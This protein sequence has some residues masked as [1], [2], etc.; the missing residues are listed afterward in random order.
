MRAKIPKKM[1]ELS[2]LLLSQYKSCDLSADFLDGTTRSSPLNEL[3]ETI[4]ALFIKSAVEGQTWFGII[5]KN[6][7]NQHGPDWFLR[8]HLPVR[9]SPL[10]SPLLSITAI[11]HRVTEKKIERGLINKQAAFREFESILPHD[12]NALHTIYTYSEQEMRLFRYVMLLNANKVV[13]NS[14]KNSNS[15]LMETFITPLYIDHPGMS[16]DFQ[17]KNNFP[18]TDAP[19]NPVPRSMASR[20]ETVA[21]VKRDS[22]ENE[23]CTKCGVSGDGFKRCARCKQVKYCSVECQ[24]LDWGKHKA[25]CSTI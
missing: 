25:T 1:Q 13:T 3:R 11:D 16:K 6:S 21:A 23:S 17:L 14:R 4:R 24:K 9:I 2:T 22:K 20:P 5:D 12:V 7:N 18:S 8:V 10:G 15:T 19:Q